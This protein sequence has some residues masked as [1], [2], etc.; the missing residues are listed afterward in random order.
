MVVK[1]FYKFNVE[2]RKETSRYSRRRSL[3]SLYKI[4]DAEDYPYCPK[5][6]QESTYRPWSQY[7]K[8][9]IEKRR[10]DREFWFSLGMGPGPTEYPTDQE[11]I[12]ILLLASQFTSQTSPEVRV[13]SPVW[14][15]LNN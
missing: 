4:E 9:F 15:V 8:T 7:V 3:A 5:Y 1:N 2:R 12:A 10:V 11:V 13:P 14:C 6:Y